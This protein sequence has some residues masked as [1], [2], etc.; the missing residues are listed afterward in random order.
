[1]AVTDD[2]V[3]RQNGFLEACVADQLASQPAV[4]QCS[5]ARWMQRCSSAA[6]AVIWFG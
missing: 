5:S 3:E 6:S 2:E 1:M 4:Q